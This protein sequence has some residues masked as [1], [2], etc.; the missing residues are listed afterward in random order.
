[1]STP[2][3]PASVAEGSKEP[4]R[5]GP[6]DAL[7]RR[8]KIIV[9]TAVLLV[10]VVGASSVLQTKQYTASATLL[11]RSTDFAQQLFGT[12]FLPPSKDPSRDAA[13]NQNLVRLRTVADRTADA[14]K[15]G[16]TG[17]E[18][19]DRVTAEPQGASD[20][21]L[22]KAVDPSPERAARIATEFARQFVQFRR[23]ADQRVVN[24]AGRLVTRELGAMTPAQKASS[25]GQSLLRRQGQLE[26]LA[27]L[28]TGNAELVQAA[29][30]PAHPSSPRTKRNVLLAAVLG[31]VL[32]AG[33]ALFV[34][35][36]DQG[37][38][39]VRDVEQLLP[40]PVLAQVPRRGGLSAGDTGIHPTSGDLDAF[41]LL[42]SHLRYFNVDGKVRTLL[43]TSAEAGAGKTTVAIGLGLALAQGGDR[44]VL[45]EA[46]LRRP[47]LRAR[48]GRTGAREGLAEVLSGELE[49]ADALTTET[50][51]IAG[52][53]PGPSIT[54]LGAGLSAPNPA[55][56]LESARMRALL[57]EL[58]EQFDIVV[59]D[60]APPLLIPDSTP[61]LR[62]VDGVVA[63]CRIGGTKRSG[64]SRLAAYLRSID[65]PLLG[66]V[67]N[68][69]RSSRHGGYGYGY[70]YGDYESNREDRTLVGRA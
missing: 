7:Q 33:I 19:A 13:T 27:S 56:L 8:W 54:V 9:A 20:L 58:R 15:N 25:Q 69:I 42:R 68:D 40:V 46:D 66:S 3:D 70:G 60:S 64:A 65:S 5:E 38:R 67:V 44:V 17:A 31:L 6:W 53:G 59:V 1:M 28:Q 16:L 49:L 21:V 43:V 45:V 2:F 14:L 4:N 39:S 35:R 37:I 24:A 30:V 48:L 61:L 63:V 41:R 62:I 12:N 36:L 10:V 47:A 11:F 22:V 55:E 29:A 57:A 34:D 32:G 18:I 51:E 26:I 23:D 50:V 52:A